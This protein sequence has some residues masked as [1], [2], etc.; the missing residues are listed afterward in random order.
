MKKIIFAFPVVALLAAG[1]NSSSSQPT[2]QQNQPVQQTQTAPSQQVAQSSTPTPVTTPS[3][4]TPQTTGLKTVTNVM[5]HFSVKIPSDYNLVEDIS[6]PNDPI[7]TRYAINNAT[8]NG[9]QGT[10]NIQMQAGWTTDLS[11]DLPDFIG[12]GFDAMDIKPFKST[13]GLIGV[14]YNNNTPNP[15]AH[16]A[17]LEAVV[18]PYPVSL[19]QKVQPTTLPKIQDPLIDISMW[20]ITPFTANQQALFMAV[21]NSLQ[22]TN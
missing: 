5:L 4:A 13:S 2:T 15:P 1:C 16:Y 17:G 20:N 12:S 11:K 9:M 18:V 21:V 8:D 22:F 19:L 7:Y 14:I 6:S 3:P 10:I